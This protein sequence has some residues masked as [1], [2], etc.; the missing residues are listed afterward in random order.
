VREQMTVLIRNIER[1]RSDTTDA[2]QHLARIVLAMTTQAENISLSTYETTVTWDKIDPRNGEE[3][4]NEVKTKVEGL[5]LALGSNIISHEA[6]VT[7]LSKLIETMSDYETN[8]KLIGEKDKILKSRLEQ[9]RLSDS[10]FLQQ[11]L[12]AIEKRMKEGA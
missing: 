2:W 10:E 9:D 5:T 6:A 12:G 8:G 11:Q 3:I 4:A 1:K 7:Y